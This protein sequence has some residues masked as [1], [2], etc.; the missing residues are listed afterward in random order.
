MVPA[1]LTSSWDLVH[2]QLLLQRVTS[3]ALPP[4]ATSR[5]STGTSSRVAAPLR[6]PCRPLT[7]AT[8]LCMDLQQLQ[9]LLLWAVLGP[10]SGYSSKQQSSSEA[11]VPGQQPG[12]QGSGC[13]EIRQQ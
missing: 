7:H 8:Q 6:L 9:K 13:A 1:E 11:C 2:M 12:C 5:S 3:T 10:A 4:G